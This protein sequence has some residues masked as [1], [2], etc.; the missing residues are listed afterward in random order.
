[1]GADTRVET[2][3]L[4]DGHGVETFH[5]SIGV[6]FVKVADAQSEVSVGEELHGFGFFHADEE[7]GNILFDSGLLEQAC[8]DMGAFGEPVDVSESLDRLVFI[9][10]LLAVHHLGNTHNDAA[11]I[12]V[13]VEGF[14]FAQ[15]FRA[16]EQVELLD[17]L[18]LVFHIEAAGVTHGDGALD[19]HHGVWIHFQDCIDDGLYCGGVEEVLLGVVVSGG[20]DDHEVGIAVT[21]LLVEGRLEAQR[22]VGEIILDVVV[23][24]GRLFMVHQINAFGNDVDSGDIIMLGQQSGDGKTDIAGTGNRNIHKK[25]V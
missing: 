2:N 9:L 8:E 11:G 24:N 15:E 23:L 18:L 12:K 14:R 22:L 13:V 25:N 19:D 5:L 6:Q 20:G 3:T 17:A 4:N 10:I 21:G 1:M 16:E 7:H